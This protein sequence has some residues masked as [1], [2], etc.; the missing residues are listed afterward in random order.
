MTQYTEQEIEEL[1]KQIEGLEVKKFSYLPDD[2]Y[3]V[4]ETDQGKLTFRFKADLL[5]NDIDIQKKIEALEQ[6]LKE[7]EETAKEKTS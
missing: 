4:I 1:K 2:D 6:K 5:Q 3:F 7:C